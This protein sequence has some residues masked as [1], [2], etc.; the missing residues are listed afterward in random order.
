MMLASPPPP[1]PP[2]TTTTP[3]LSVFPLLSIPALCNPFLVDPFLGDGRHTALTLPAPAAKCEYDMVQ[4]DGRCCPF[5]YVCTASTTMHHHLSLLDVL[6]LMSVSCLSHV[7]CLMSHVVDVLVNNGQTDRWTDRLT[8]T[9]TD[10]HRQTTA[11]G[12]TPRQHMSNTT[13]IFTHHHYQQWCL[14]RVV[15]VH[16]CLSLRVVFVY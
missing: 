15:F 16:V 4:R 12:T 9:N 8:Q 13:A 14:A 10:Q 2:P 1:P 5:C 3:T 6:C 7:S 11:D